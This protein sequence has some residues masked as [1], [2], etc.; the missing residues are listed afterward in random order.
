M[1]DLDVLVVGGGI[2]GL[3]TATSLAQ[4]GLS[5][6]VWE[7]E[8]RAGGKIQSDCYAGYLTE[9]AA[10]MVM[11]FRPEVGQFI[12]RSGLESLKTPRVATQN[13]Q[14]YV[15][16]QG[17]LQTIPKTLTGM[18][19]SPLWSLRGK[20][21]LLAEPLVPRTPQ[22]CESVAAFVRR[23]LGAELLDKAME[24]FIAGTLASDPEQADVRSVL[25]RMLALEQR[26][27]SIALGVVVNK[28]LRRGTAMSQNIFSFTGG[29]SGM[30]QQLAGQSGLVFKSLHE[31]MM[32]EPAGDGWRVFA[33]TPEGER[34][35]RTRHLVLS[36]PAQDTANLIRQHD[37]ELAD[38]LSGIAYAP[39]N[40]VHIGFTRNAIGHP[41]N[42]MGFLVPGSERMRITGCQ[43]MSSIF[44]QRAPEEHVLMTCYLGGCRLPQA[45]DWSDDSCIDAVLSDLWNSLSLRSSPEMAR[46]IRHRRAL[47]LYHGNYHAR[48]KHIELRAGAFP[49]LHLQANYLGGVSVRDRIAQA[50]LLARQIACAPCPRTAFGPHTR[51]EMA[52][53]A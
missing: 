27:G 7:R 19:R 52:A 15:M 5:V 9:Q 44:P 32:I 24:P 8:Q 42:G 43:W 38:L 29:M 51:L 48:C 4:K 14:R 45:C 50:L 31:V 10:S 12:Q 36:T 26:Y 3:A 47:P 20:M 13:E 28:L 35:V 39:L 2:S 40:V 53:S 17:R 22:S 41:L 11:N 33:Q 1:S 6:A 30:I 34:N 49:G 21:R 18:I 46:V 23:R 37:V 16:H 25:P